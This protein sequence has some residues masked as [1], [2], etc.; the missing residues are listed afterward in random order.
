M[1]P[2]AR[3]LPVNLP[4]SQ[5][6]EIEQLKARLLELEQ[7]RDSVIMTQSKTRKFYVQFRSFLLGIA[8]EIDR[9]F[10]ISTKYQVIK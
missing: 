4:V 1:T 5:E 8:D 2:E 9:L 6:A 3:G 7:W 10:V